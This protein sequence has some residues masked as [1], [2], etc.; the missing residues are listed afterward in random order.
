MIAIAGVFLL[1]NRIL[2]SMLDGFILFLLPLPIMFYSAKYGWKT[3]WTVIT[4]GILLGAVISTPQTL[5][6]TA[7][8]FL[9][10]AVCGAGV[11]YK[12]NPRK[13]MVRAMII[14]AAA[15]LLAMVVL[16]D[17]FGYD[18]NEEVSSFEAVMEKA[19][20][21]SGSSVDLTSQPVDFTR[22]IKELIVISAALTGVLEA[23]VTMFL[24]RMMLKR[25][26]FD[27]VKMTPLAE[28]YPP[29]IT[30]WIGLAGVL[31]YAYSS[32]YTFGSEIVQM[33]LQGFGIIMYMYLVMWGILAGYVSARVIGHAGKGILIL[34][35]LLGFMMEFVAMIVGLFYIA[36]PLH[37]HIMMKGD[38]HA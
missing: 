4:A 8:A 38:Q 16:G 9:I 1:I 25:L 31:A 2:G 15:E 7:A 18:L 21:K 22:L 33:I 11:Y 24:G 32:Y 26:K 17:L 14:G 6:Y 3:T 34:F 13:T 20:E 36:G 27:L 23:Y 19:A 12:D 37:D 5:F 35:I 29:K 30:G 10:G 28:Y